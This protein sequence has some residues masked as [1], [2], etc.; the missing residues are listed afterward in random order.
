MQ[1][2]ELRKIF[3]EAKINLIEFKIQFEFEYNSNEDFAFSK[4]NHNSALLTLH[5]A[6]RLTLHFSVSALIILLPNTKNPKNFFS[7]LLKF[8]NVFDT[9][10]VINIL[11]ELSSP[12]KK[13]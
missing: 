7:P 1:S 11:L 9:I 10:K 8:H 4:I 13:G 5:S 2:A 12:Q 6:L 3:A